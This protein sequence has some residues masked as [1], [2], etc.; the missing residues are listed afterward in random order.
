[1]DE[2]KDQTT[3]FLLPNGDK[4]TK[5]SNLI[6]YMSHQLK[7]ELP[8]A[9]DVR[10][11]GA[12]VAA[13]TCNEGDVRLVTRQLAHDPRVHAQYYECIRGRKDAKKAYDIMQS[14]MNKNECGKKGVSCAVNY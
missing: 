11:G 6:R 3:L 2:E 13:T 4:V 12:T 14:V 9:T 7:V 10:K 1:M 8:C 5:I